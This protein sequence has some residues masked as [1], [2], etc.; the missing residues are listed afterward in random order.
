MTI[1]NDIGLDALI[2]GE[3]SLLRA[4][5]WIFLIW[6][7]VKGIFNLVLGEEIFVFM[8]VTRQNIP[9]VV[10]FQFLEPFLHFSQL[11]IQLYLQV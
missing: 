11:F 5:E 7:Q 10:D 3:V 6:M 9:F 4:V 8:E 1:C 2:D